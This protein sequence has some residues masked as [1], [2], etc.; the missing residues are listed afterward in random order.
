GTARGRRCIEI[1][2]APSNAASDAGGGVLWRAFPWSTLSVAAHG[3][4]R[5]D[6]VVEPSVELFGRAADPEVLEGDEIQPEVGPTVAPRDALVA[7]IVD[8]VDP[9]LERAVATLGVVQAH[10]RLDAVPFAGILG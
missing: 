9:H 5:H 2:R 7:A 1:L 6:D 3:L 10:V 8:A 4:S